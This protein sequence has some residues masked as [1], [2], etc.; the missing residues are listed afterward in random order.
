V[1]NKHGKDIQLSNQNQ[2]AT[3][4]GNGW[5]NHIVLGSIPMSE[6]TYYW[7]LEM[8]Q[9]NDDMYGVSPDIP[10]M[11]TTAYY[12]SNGFFIHHTSNI[13]G[14]I[15]NNER[16]NF[17]CREKGTIMGFRISFT[18]FTKILSV[19]KNRVFWNEFNISH[20]P[21]P[22]YTTVE[23]HNPQAQCTILKFEREK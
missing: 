2:T 1:W 9:S 10:D 11:N 17:S 6:G 5:R 16:K 19:Y 13:F 20:L 4:V 23:L 21:V 18:Q 3:S 7:E 14:Q 15:G 22:L 8:N 12:Y